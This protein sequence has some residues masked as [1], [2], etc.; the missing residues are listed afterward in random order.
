MRFSPLAGISLAE[1]S[2][3]E[4]VVDQILSFSPLAGISLA[5][6]VCVVVFVVCVCFVSVP[7]RGLV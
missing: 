1:S 2:V 4:R 6:S 3:Q 7:L 5:E